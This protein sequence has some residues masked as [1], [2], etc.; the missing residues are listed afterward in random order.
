MLLASSAPGDV[1]A[2]AVPYA[3]PPP[4][5]AA[6]TFNHDG[7]PLTVSAFPGQVQV[8]FNTPVPAATARALITGLGATV[9]AQI[10]GVGYA[11]AGVPPGQESSFIDQVRANA[12]VYLA[13]PH[14]AGRYAGTGV[15]VVDDCDGSHGAAVKKVLTDRGVTIEAC[16]DDGDARPVSIWTIWE[17]ESQ[18]NANKTNPTLINIS[19]YQGLTGTADWEDQPDGI[20]R[21]VLTEYSYDR[22][23]LLKTISQMPLEYRENLVITLCAGNNHMPLDSILAEIAGSPALLAVLRNNILIV[24][25]AG[26]SFSNYA[27]IFTD[28][29]AWV[30]N[31]ESSKGTSYAA[32]YALALISKIMDQR[33]VSAAEALRIVKDAVAANPN[34][35]LV[36]SEVLPVAPGDVYQGSIAGETTD[37]LDGSVWKA[38]VSLDLTLTVS[39]TGIL[40]DPYD[41]QLDF[42]GTLIETLIQCDEPGGCD[43]G[44]T[45]PVSGTGQQTSLG[46]VIG[47]A[48]LGGTDDGLTV[49]LTDGEFSGDRTKLTGT[50]TVASVA[51]DAPV[52][53]EVT[54]NLK[55]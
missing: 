23:S 8:I 4:A 30:S 38:E 17:T 53:K 48:L 46:K 36:E 33:G 16:R 44:G 15:T 10:P 26:Q 34:H 47:T 27:S 37:T 18:I 42:S 29:F 54:L 50:V 3:G 12:S 41:V 45:Y 5:P 13:F 21:R 28:D 40:G 49:K 20:K 2:G 39:G 1:F 35:E 51:F 52:I 55:P 6:V 9:L 32:P 31:P 11:L 14:L 19:S 22:K 24:G 43:P 25:S 7:L